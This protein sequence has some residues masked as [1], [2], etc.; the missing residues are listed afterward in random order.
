MEE[1]HAWKGETVM[2]MQVVLGV[3]TFPPRYKPSVQPILAPQGA[4]ASVPLPFSRAGP[5]AQSLFVEGKGVCFR[6]VF[7][8]NL[9]SQSLWNTGFI[10]PIF[11][12][13]E[14]EPTN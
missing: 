5:G 7:P 1:V 11:T 14:C 2:Q 6:A 9:S 3:S 13:E 12:G 8:S 4:L 10:S